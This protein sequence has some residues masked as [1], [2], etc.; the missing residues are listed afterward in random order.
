LQYYQNFVLIICLV[1]NSL[2]K[3]KVCKD[4]AKENK[5]RV[6]FDSKKYNFN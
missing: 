5:P 2:E 4:C 6:C 1:K 3:D